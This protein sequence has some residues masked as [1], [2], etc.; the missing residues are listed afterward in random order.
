MPKLVRFHIVLS[1]LL[2][3]TIFLVS[4]DWSSPEAK[5]AKHLERA[6]SYSEKGQYQ[7]ALIEYQ[8]VAKTDPKDADALTVWH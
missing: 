8:N 4:C 7:E 2:L 6:A 5:K 3:T 1:T